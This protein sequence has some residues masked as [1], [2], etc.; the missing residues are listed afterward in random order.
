MSQVLGWLRVGNDHLAV[1]TNGRQWR[2]LFA[3]LDFDAWCEWDLE[4][5]FEHG[6]LSPQVTALRTLLRPELWTPESEGAEAP[7]LQAIRDTRK[8]QAELS[9]VLG[10]RVREA[11]ELLIQGHGEALKERCGTV[12][13]ADIYRAACRVAMRL[14]VIL[15]AESRE[16]LP[17][18]N[19][20]YHESY[21]LNG[22]LDQLER[23]AT[24]PGALAHSFGGWPRVL[25]LFALVRDGSHHPDLPVTAYGGDLFSPGQPDAA[26]GLSHALSVFESA[27]FESEVLP[28]H[29]VYEMLKL[30]TRTTIRIRQGRGGTRAVVPVDFSDLSSEYIGMRRR[31]TGHRSSPNESWSSRSATRLAGPGPFRWPLCASSR[32]RCTPRSSITAASN[33]KGRVPWSGCWASMV[34]STRTPHKSRASPTS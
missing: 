12:D 11:V 27:C 17:R 13:P 30:L 5:W 19:S 6:E 31:Q 20:L 9:E 14:V 15:F 10:E 8:G 21:G 1:V 33:R 2:L 32:R 7:L 29:D 18:D 4:L 23:A 28:D 3:G 24:R 22:L 34:R 26:E 25:A 16:L